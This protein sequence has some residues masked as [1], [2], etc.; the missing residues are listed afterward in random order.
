MLERNM[1]TKW[2][3][4]KCQNQRNLLAKIPPSSHKPAT[5]GNHR[6]NLHWEE[7][8]ALGDQWGAE[9]R[10]RYWG[11]YLQT[12]RQ[13]IWQYWREAWARG[14]DLPCWASPAGWAGPARRWRP[15]SPGC[16]G[17]YPVWW[18]SLWTWL[19]VPTLSS[20]SLPAGHT[21]RLDYVVCSE[22]WQN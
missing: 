19:S 20:N 8:E 17:Q 6:E 22:V 13:R 3:I 14:G 12:E 15:Q 4:L 1:F 11:K 16:C 21:Q 18:E 7:I 9:P 5:P 2:E 10:T